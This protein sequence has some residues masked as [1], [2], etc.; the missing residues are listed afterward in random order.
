MTKIELA[1]FAQRWTEERARLGFSQADMARIMGVSRETIRKYENGLTWPGGENLALAAAAGL[2]IAFIFLGKRTE[3]D[4]V[5]AIAPKTH[6]G[7]HASH[8][9]IAN[10]NAQIINTQSHRT[11]TKAEVKPGLEHIEDR[12][13]AILQRLVKEIVETEAR[14]KKAPASHRAVWARLNSFCGV[15]QYRLIK[16]E[17]FDRARKYLD[18]WMGRL[19]S[20]ASAPVKDGDSWRK[21]HYS[22]IKVNS[23]HPEDDA[24][25]KTYMKANFGAD[26]MT[27]L[28]NDEL[29]QLYK[30]VAGRR[31][32]SS[33]RR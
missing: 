28:S 20:L 30:Y 16:S 6:V 24:A 1:Q 12:Q 18:Q 27:E 25:V 7:D 9:F 26:S 15:P 8:V 21:R 23:K 19:H 32:R 13:A 17:D 31:N 11:I 10:E 4:N 14:L 33:N 2:D 3:A 5:G 29:E 22:Y